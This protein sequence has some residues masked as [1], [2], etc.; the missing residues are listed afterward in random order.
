MELA[1]EQTVVVAARVVPVPDRPSS[2]AAGLEVK[3]YTDWSSNDRGEHL[4]QLLM[5]LRG[6]AVEQ[7][8]D[9]EVGKILHSEAEQR[10]GNWSSNLV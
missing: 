1:A 7:L 9:W 3:N 10:T 6:K 8:Q 5:A 2:F 4:A